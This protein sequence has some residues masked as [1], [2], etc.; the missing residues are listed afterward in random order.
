MAFRGVAR[1]SLAPLQEATTP[2]PRAALR[3]PHYRTGRSEPLRLLSASVDAAPPA[4][5]RAQAPPLPTSA[6]VPSPAA[7]ARVARAS[8]ASLL[9]PPLAFEAQVVGGEPMLVATLSVGPDDVAAMPFFLTP[10]E[11]AGLARFV[12]EG[13]SD[14]PQMLMLTGSIKSGKSRVLGTVLPGLLAA[15][16]AAAPQSRRRPVVF[17]H[18]FPL[19]APVDVAA[20]DLVDRL[21]YFAQSQGASLPPPPCALSSLPDVVLQLAGHVHAEGGELWL[22]FDELQAPVVASTPAEAAFFVNK[23]KRIVELCA[24]FARIV[25]TGSGMVSLLTA[26]RG[27]APNGFAL[28]DAVTHLSLG[29]EPRAPAALA[30]AERI[31]TAR[32]RAHRWPPAFAALL[33]PQRACDELA[34]GAH[35][36]LTSPRPALV[37]FLC[38]LVGDARSGAPE[39]VLE[40]AVSAVLSKLES[41]SVADTVTALT[42]MRPELRSWLR[43][44]AAQDAPMLAMR[45]HLAG[46][47]LGRAVANFASLLCEPSEPPRL[48]PPYGALLRS[49]VTRQGEL[50]VTHLS[51]GR[52]EYAPLLRSNLQLIVEHSG[53]PRASQHSMSAGALSAASASVLD[54]FAAN[55][56]GIM[57]DGVA[58]TRA[59]RTIAEVLAVPAF[60]ALLAVLDEHVA[61]VGRPGASPASTALAS[62]ARASSS[63]QAGFLAALGVRVL[64]WLRHVDASPNAMFEAVADACAAP[65]VAVAVTE[66]FP[67]A[68][69]GCS[70]AFQRPWSTAASTE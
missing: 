44:L 30:M 58:T 33:T 38:G 15:R 17:L 45:R 62:A 4:A 14:V 11:H 35:G 32:A 7:A 57:E 1:W 59:P 5:A 53:I 50:A 46:N 26:V 52:L 20:R 13:R 3:L 25:G 47:S 39:A 2:L 70:S 18:S 68:G 19:D 54:V 12:D 55:G 69:D 49:L 24:P 66:K 8:R 42:R 9:P 60:A 56:I 10:A 41:E 27:S 29:H 65:Q 22:L 48:L 37:A 16:L 23:F 67:P 31:L 40:R 51:S 43:A 61:R 34:L 6:A 28:W 64:T 63:E 36:E 21:L